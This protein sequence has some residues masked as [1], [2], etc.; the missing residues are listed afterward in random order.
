VKGIIC[1]KPV[2]DTLDAADRMI[3][4]C[5]QKRVPLLVNYTRRYV[6]LY[7]QVKRMLDAGELG[8][9][10]GV[11]AYY[12]AGAVNTGTHLFDFLRYFFGEADW[13]FADPSRAIGDKDPSYSGYIHFKKGFGCTLTALNVSDYLVFEA[14]IYGSKRRLRLKESGTEAE[15]WK[16]VPHPMFSGYKALKGERMLKGDLGEGLPGLVRNLVES[17]A[18][19]G[20]PVCSGEDG[21]ASFEIAAALHRSF[22]NGGKIVHMPVKDRKLRLLSK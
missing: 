22:K 11:S 9:I 4:A 1:E 13:A 5:A 8:D 17:V 7:R 6:R 18:K 16:A 12:T 10:Q 21:R 19:K 14:D 15:V 2:A 20:K 3:R